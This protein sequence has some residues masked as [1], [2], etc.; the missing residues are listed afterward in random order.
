VRRTRRKGCSPSRG[1]TSAIRDRLE[2]VEDK[3]S[4][5]PGLTCVLTPG[6]TPGGLMLML[7]S[8]GDRLCCIGDLIHHETELRKHDVF[9]IFDVDKDEAFAHESAS[10]RSWRI[11][12]SSSSAALPVSRLGHI[13]REGTRLHGGRFRPCLLEG[14]PAVGPAGEPWYPVSWHPSL[15]GPCGDAQRRF[16]FHLPL[17]K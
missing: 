9:A 13:V 14:R 3:A 7:S 16:L 6:H 8:G 12:D 5:V 2:F 1:E 17:L 4:I 11:L 15:R 10:C